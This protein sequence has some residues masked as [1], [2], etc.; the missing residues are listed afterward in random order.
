METARSPWRSAARINT[1]AFLSAERHTNALRER[2]KDTRSGGCL[3]APHAWE[4]HMT[5]AIY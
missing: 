2:R 5:T 3:V 4:F 1:I